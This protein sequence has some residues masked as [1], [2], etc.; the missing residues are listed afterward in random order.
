MLFGKILKVPFFGRV[1]KNSILSR[2]QSDAKRYVEI[3]QLKK[4]FTNSLFGDTVRKDI[5][6]KQEFKSRR[7]MKTEY[8]D[9]AEEEHKLEN[10]GY[11]VKDKND[12]GVDDDESSKTNRV[13]SR[14]GAFTSNNS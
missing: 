10:R 11:I 6:F 12:E 1:V 4:F 14:F 7:R 3:E 2:K 13:S 8:D 5:D 9:R